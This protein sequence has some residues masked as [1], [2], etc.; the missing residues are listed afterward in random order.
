MMQKD[1]RLYKPA[2][3]AKI[4]GMTKRALRH[5]NQL[6]LLVP[7]YENNAG[8]RFYSDDNFFEAQRILSL[9]YI[10]FSLEDIRAIQKSH[11]GIEESLELQRIILQEKADQIQ[12][13]IKSITDMENTLKQSGEIVWDS[14]FSKVKLAKYETVKTKMMEYY[15][16]RANEY[17]DIF[18]GKG[19]ATYSPQYYVQD[20]EKIGKFM[21]NFG[22]GSIIDIACGSGYWLKYYYDKCS[23]FTFLDQSLQ[24]LK[25]CR[26]TIEEHNISD[27]SRLIAG[28]I[29]EY[30]FAD[31]E[32]FDSAVVGFLLGHFTETQDKVFF[33]KLKSILRPGSEILFIDSTWTKE[34][35][36][37][38]N[39]ED[40]TERYLKDGRSFKI[41]K[42]YFDKEDLQTL[43]SKYGISVTASFFGSTFTAVIGKV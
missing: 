24:M 17:D 13:I 14:I 21:E 25:V 15:D 8:H 1:K 10:G 6:G 32:K 31:G 3:F 19:P 43:L 37:N 4:V 30:S 11:K 16:E 22:K 28:D 42:R 29:L 35:A 9:R 33:E 26:Q 5:Y 18:E 40:I 36:K 38:Q 41:Y 27:I 2:E 23:N 7:S 39:K 20:I 34:R 12:N